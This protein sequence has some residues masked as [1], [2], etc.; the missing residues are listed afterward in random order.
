THSYAGIKKLN[1]PAI[2]LPRWPPGTGL[3]PLPR[4]GDG[5]GEGFPNRKFVTPH[6]ERHSASKTRVNALMAIRPLPMGEAERKASGAA[7]FPLF[8]AGD[9]GRG[10]RPRPPRRLVQHHH[11]GAARRRA[12]A[13]VE[14]RLRY[15]EG[16]AAKR[17]ERRA[18]DDLARPAQFAQEVD[19]LAHQDEGRVVDADAEISFTEHGDPAR[20][21]IGGE[22]GVVD[23]ALRI[24]V[25]VTD[26]V[27]DAV[28]IVGELRRWPAR[29]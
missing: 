17:G 20:L 27:A 3:L 28:R 7:I 15:G 18:D 19:F 11:G 22:H 8:E 2:R 25:G 12:G 6:P 1:G 9:L 10:K 26:D 5:W 16:G 13:V 24:E 4:W 23:V 14:D 29:V 21:E